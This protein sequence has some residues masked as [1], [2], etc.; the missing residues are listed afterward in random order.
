MQLLPFLIGALLV[1]LSAQAQEQSAQKPRW[2]LV[3]HGG[4]GIIEKD[5]GTPAQ[6]A[7][8]RAGLEAA[9]AAGSRVLD[10]GGDALDAVQAAVQVLED[11]PHFNAGRGAVF[12][13]EGRNELDA[14]IDLVPLA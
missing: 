12:T 8:V 6:E 5:K 3:I 13:W 4:A 11:D 1:P 10:G 14:A 7:G 2:T 9:L